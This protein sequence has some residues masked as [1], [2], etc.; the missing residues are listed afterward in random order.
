MVK[1]RLKY[2]VED[3]D[4][5][6]NVRLYVRLP[7]RKKIR[8]RGVPGTNEFMRA[9]SDA[10]AAT[11]INEKRAKYK[12]PPQG[13]FGYICLRYFSSE[14]FKALDISTQKWRRRSLNE[15][16][17][18]H[19]DKP[20]VQMRAN[21]VRKL[22]DEKRGKP[23]AARNRLKA[24]KAL[25]A[26]AMEEELAAHD[27][28][29]GVRPVRYISTPHHTWT[30]D[31][32]S[33]FEET[34]PIGTR[35]RD[36]LIILLYTGGRREDAVRLGPRHIRNDRIIFCQAKNEHRK[37]VEVDIPMHPD[38]AEI[39]RRIPAQNTT[40][41]MTEYG[42]PFTP[43]GFGNAFRK[44]CN[45]AGLP[46]CSAH[47]LRKATATLLAESGATAHEI[48]SVTGHQT[49]EEV[50]RYT[51]NARRQVLADSAMAKLRR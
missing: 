24:L 36:A 1:I 7:G 13:S 20:I 21:H 30:I 34:F 10:I 32:I 22:R 4:R 16:C 25:F 47:G 41:L 49:L 8:I 15:I 44:W 26:W 3:V 43:N 45:R 12:C 42:K 9:Y 11:D 27:P 17:E 38:L 19:G 46:H 48:M 6:G 18:R 5:H 14:T 29:H 50:E 39:V 35:P 23:G 28:T 2:L 51:R 31:E 40:F 37:P 33:K